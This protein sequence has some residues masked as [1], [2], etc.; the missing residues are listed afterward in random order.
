MA[1]N[2]I[3]IKQQEKERKNKMKKKKKKKGK[4]TFANCR[5]FPTAKMK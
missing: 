5:S 3:I 2:K 1:D 4:K